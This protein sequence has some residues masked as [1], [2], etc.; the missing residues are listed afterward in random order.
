MNSSKSETFINSIKEELRISASPRPPS[1]FYH[2]TTPEQLNFY[3]KWPRPA[4]DQSK[5]VYSY[6]PIKNYAPIKPQHFQN[7]LTPS[8]ENSN[9]SGKL[10]FERIKEI[11][12]MKADADDVPKISTVF[13][14]DLS[15]YPKIP[16]SFNTPSYGWITFSLGKCNLPSKFEKLSIVGF[17]Q[18]FDNKYKNASSEQIKFRVV[19]GEAIFTQAIASTINF[20]LYAK[21]QSILC[22]ISRI[23][24]HSNN[25]VPIALNLA[26][27]INENGKFVSS[28]EFSK[29]WALFTNDYETT[30]KK[31][32]SEDE[33]IEK[34]EIEFH[35]NSNFSE[36]LEREFSYSWSQTPNSNFCVCPLP[37]LSYMPTP[38]ILAFDWS[39]NNVKFPQNATRVFLKMFISDE[40]ENIQK[41]KA[42]KLFNGF[43][44]GKFVDAFSTSIADVSQKVQF[45]E[46]VSIYVDRE[47]KQ[48]AHIAI[49]IYTI[50]K[51]AKEPSLFG[52][53]ALPF[54]QEGSPVNRGTYKLKIFE[55]KK[56]PKDLK[57]CIE[58]PT[59]KKSFVQCT[60]NLPSAYFP[61]LAVK[62]V[63][64]ALM[65]EQALPPN[66]KELPQ[67]VY[68]R[69]ILPMFGKLLTIIAPNTATHLI[70]FIDVFEDERNQ[71]IHIIKTWIYN[72]MNPSLFG[73]NFINDLCSAFT[74]VIDENSKNS[75]E[76]KK[77][78]RTL[79]L[80][81]DL[82][83]I[84][85]TTPEIKYDKKYII[86]LLNRIPELICEVSNKKI[87]QFKAKLD[88]EGMNSNRRS[89][90]EQSSEHVFELGAS[91]IGNI[92]EAVKLNSSYA[93][94]L[95]CLLPLFGFDSISKL[96]FNHIHL[97][98]IRKKK[99]LDRANL[100]YLQ[101]SFLMPFSYSEQFIVGLTS[102]CKISETSKMSAFVPILS[103]IFLILHVSFNSN[104][105][106]AVEVAC[107]FFANICLATENVPEEV[108]QKI[109]FIIFPLI[110]TISAN[111]EGMTL[112]NRPKL[113][114]AFIPI[115]LYILRFASHSLIRKFF[116][117]L[118]T[119]FQVHFL[120]FLQT[121][122]RVVVDSLNM[123]RPLI[124]PNLLSNHIM[125]DMKPIPNKA[126][127]SGNSSKIDL[128]MFDIA[129][130]HILRFISA[131]MD[132]LGPHVEI[133][134]NLFSSLYNSYQ[135]IDNVKIF[136]VT[137]LKL[138]RTFP[139]ARSL[140]AWLLSLISFEQHDTR[141]LACALLMM[142]FKADYD[143]SG[144]VVISSVDMM[145][146]LTAVLL[147]VPLKS[148]PIYKLLLQRF[149]E[150]T[151]TYNNKT[152]EKLL[153]ERMEAS[154]II[155][156][157]VED[158]KKSTFPPEIRCQHIMRIAD[159]YK[160][161][162]SMRLKWLL[163]IVKVDTELKNFSS[164]FIAQLHVCA[165]I[166]TVVEQLQK[167]KNSEKVDKSSQKSQSNS[168]KAEKDENTGFYLT[169]TQPMRNSTKANIFNT[170]QDFSFM[171]G[172][173]GEAQLDVAKLAK[174]A[175]TL[176]SDF[177]TNLLLDNLDR[178]IE[179]G[180]S[181]QLH[182]SLRPLHSLQLRIYQNM[183]DY[184][185]IAK[186]L[187]KLS[188]SIANVQAKTNC[189]YDTP[190]SFFLVEYRSENNTKTPN[191]QVFCVEFNQINHFL[192]AINSMN[193]FD[194]LKAEYCT[195]HS[196][197]C[198]EKG[199][200]IVRLH[201]VMQSK[202]ANHK[203]FIHKNEFDHCFNSF[204]AYSAINNDTKEVHVVECT[205]K[206]YLPH[207]R[208]AADV[209]KLSIKSETIFDHVEQQIDIAAKLLEKVASEFEVWY[210][211]K[212]GK[213][214]EDKYVI[215]DIHR[216]SAVVRHVLKG[217]DAVANLL[218]ILKEKKG[219]ETKKL[220]KLLQKRLARLLNIYR[221]AVNELEEKQPN[222]QLLNL[223][224]VMAEEFA[225][226]FNL[227]PI[228]KID[229]VDNYDPMDDGIDFK[230]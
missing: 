1:G 44:Q 53:A 74:T 135:P 143:N 46:Q 221:R 56:P 155:S 151:K 78:C 95:S 24:E 106:E 83:I 122:V 145:D 141:C 176:L 35:F 6:T 33:N 162:P 166:E 92:P 138:I 157:V 172:V 96:I 210:P 185:K 68:Q 180:K 205:T 36:K 144:T 84:S 194:G 8:E 55:V 197:K 116:T 101:F 45:I 16:S 89:F 13:P 227:E 7:D 79:P 41:P 69:Q 121:V 206:D 190:L 100:S 23:S 113:Q 196:E 107:K 211:M 201:P 117:E 39:L 11:M 70:H 207:Y 60:F 82:L 48:H 15:G 88:N 184:A 85:L 64:D 134:V 174:D 126:G 20:P 75:E 150:L 216:I 54:Y 156:N 167:D 193:R 59:T 148:I 165:L 18:L 178:A 129:T 137:V 217:N 160:T 209:S 93:N 4:F 10:E 136:Y 25:N 230:E 179:L 37:I 76:I 47:F 223:C 38:I 111:Y 169:T 131:N 228:E 90:K 120:K 3:N 158:Q 127:M 224:E 58:K 61:P 175:E 43:E 215:K 30:I 195:N 94:L 19:N 164:A 152:F 189:T 98:T 163:E 229:F 17:I 32:L 99:R 72:V 154:L 28:S 103:Q 191:R 226:Q 114:Q 125:N 26:T 5:Y 9:F 192:N 49:H 213:H 161:F 29:D 2:Q 142:I 203:S 80:V 219:K 168:E 12:N 204:V 133:V 202:T 181:A 187:E 110:N 42:L 102:Y 108:S 186:V 123:S 132:L 34:V 81:F 124:M 62:N 105:G 31:I 146:S 21:D 130:K 212:P 225:Q 128:G 52:L 170:K 208:W 71:V 140:I 65:P 73:H 87:G 14:F 139:I 77:I 149:I 86:E 67:E 222:D 153:N 57:N 159:Q 51:G 50:E 173:L 198:S 200:C 218:V 104:D 171:P 66:F 109:A 182:Y 214:P 63:I 115:V 188:D 119:S 199:V 118:G 91:Q 112:K 22:V 183:R 97:I 147:A 220:A 27:V 177:T 40:V